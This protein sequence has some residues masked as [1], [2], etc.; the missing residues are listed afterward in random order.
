VFSGGLWQVEESGSSKWTPQKRIADFESNF[1]KN[2]LTAAPEFSRGII[3]LFANGVAR[4]VS[5]GG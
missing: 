1:D 3:A 5:N 2:E 4:K